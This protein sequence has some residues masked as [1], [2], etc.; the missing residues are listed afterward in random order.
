MKPKIYLAHSSKYDFQSEFY[1]PIK[2]SPLMDDFVF[3]LDTPDFLPNT[4]KLIKSYDTVVAKIGYSTTGGG[5][6]IGWADAFNVPLI[7]IH[8]KNFHPAPYY[9]DMS[10]N[11]ISYDSPEDMVGKLQKI[12]KRL[13]RVQL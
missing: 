3:L 1:Q 10:E 13:F 5:I 9:S 11:I 6:E 7:L 8:N 12:L 4:K 2:Q